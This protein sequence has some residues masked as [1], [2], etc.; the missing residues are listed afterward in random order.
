M[1]N[2]TFASWRALGHWS[3][4]GRRPIRRPIP[5]RRKAVTRSPAEPQ[6]CD[7]ALTIVT[8]A[9]EVGA[10]RNALTHRHLGLRNDFYA[11][12]KARGQ[13]PDSDPRLRKQ[14]SAGRS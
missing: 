5:G 7:G 11:Q 3:R 4:T 1:K 14:M 9:Q 10:P 8:L 12:V 13:M 2:G 6:N